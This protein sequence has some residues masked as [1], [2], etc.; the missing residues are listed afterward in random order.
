MKIESDQ[1]MNNLTNKLNSLQKNEFSIK[2]ESISNKSKNYFDEKNPI[3]QKSIN[4]SNYNTK[5]RSKKF[6]SME[7]IQK[8]CQSKMQPKPIKSS[9]KKH[10]KKIFNSFQEEKDKSLSNKIN[11]ETQ[12]IENEKNHM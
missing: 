8:D 9:F 12:S 10:H 3:K 4:V 11:S 7:G 6:Q 1:L 2:E 5:K